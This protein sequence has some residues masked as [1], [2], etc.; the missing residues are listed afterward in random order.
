LTIWRYIPYLCI[1]NNNKGKNFPNRP[2]DCRGK[3]IRKMKTQYEIRTIAEE[4]IE[5]MGGDPAEICTGDCP[6][7]AKK[8]LTKVGY[9]QVVSNLERAMQDELSGC[10]VIAPEERWPNPNKNG[11]CSHCWVKIDGIF[12]DAFNPE[13]V[14]DEYLLDFYKNNVG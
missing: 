10:D 3:K 9:G 1:I 4:I 13:G 5:E 11:D 7:F 14:T 2:S 8:L 6:D 12:Y